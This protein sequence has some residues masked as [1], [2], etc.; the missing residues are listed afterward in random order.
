MEKDYEM[1]SNF[2]LDWINYLKEELHKIGHTVGLN[3]TP[4]EIS[5]KYFNF[6]WRSIPAKPRNVLISKEFSCPL[7]HQAGLD[8]LTK[9]IEAGENL[10][11]YLSV[12]VLLEPND[13]DGLLNDW[14]IYHL[15]LG[16]SP[17]KK[18]SNLVERT[19]SLLFARFDH[20]CAYFINIF[21]HDN[22]TNEELVQILHNN[23]SD[24]IQQFRI[25][26]IVELEEPVQNRDA[27]RKSGVLAPVQL[28]NGVVYM[29]IGGGYTSSGMGVRVVMAADNHTMKV[30]QI[31]DYVRDNLG[32]LISQ[33]MSSGVEFGD[34]LYLRLVVNDSKF[35][36]VEDNS[37]AAWYLGQ[38]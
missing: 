5:L 13:N 27:F 10:L 26:G 31:E 3:Q 32:S 25:P 34:K 36:V 12:R 17:H 16:T 15:H 20:E 14:E 29:A 22:W 9:R 37:K 6:L 33:A 21:G 2:Y 4:E 11:T 28:A 7:E 1:E 24:S 18:H 19:G 35:Y 23:W 8:I 30:R 38:F